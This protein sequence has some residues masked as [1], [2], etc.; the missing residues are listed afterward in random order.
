M[1]EF[2]VL[3]LYLIKTRNRKKQLSGEIDMST[4]FVIFVIVVGAIL[5]IIAAVA[6]GGEKT[7]TAQGKIEIEKLTKNL[8]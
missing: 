1:I 4:F 6:F 8:G 7:L 2:L 5:I 3:F